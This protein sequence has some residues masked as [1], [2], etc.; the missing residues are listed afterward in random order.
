MIERLIIQVPS[1]RG[2]LVG[3]ITIGGAPIVY[4][5]QIA[6][7]I[8]MKLIG[9]AACLGTIYNAPVRCAGR[10][11]VDLA[12]PVLLNR[13]V[14]FGSPTPIGMVDAFF[15]EISRRV[16]PS[17]KHYKNRQSFRRTR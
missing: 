4:G 8:T 14:P 12:N 10:C 5:G 2:F 3:N 9:T 17:R 11:C 1:E 15:G 7:C 13:R 16:D 6:A